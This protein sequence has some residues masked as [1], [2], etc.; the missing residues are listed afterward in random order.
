M[1]KGKDK[2]KR[3]RKE[4]LTKGVIGKFSIAK[5]PSRFEISRELETRLNHPEGAGTNRSLG[6]EKAL[7]DRIERLR[8]R[9]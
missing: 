3:Q 9:R 4:S 7:R 8:S 1:R 6:S 5:K 2:G